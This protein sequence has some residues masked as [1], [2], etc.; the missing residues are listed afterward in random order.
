MIIQCQFSLKSKNLQLV[1]VAFSFFYVD[2]EVISMCYFDCMSYPLH[3][4]EFF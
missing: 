2:A 4:L 3:S 1:S